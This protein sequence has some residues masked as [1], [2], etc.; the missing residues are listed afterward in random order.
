MILSDSPSCASGLGRITRDLATRLHEHCSDVFE[1]A[2]VGYGGTGNP[3]LK[4]REF[5]LHSVDNWLPMQLPEIWRK[6]VKEDEGILFSVWDLS[7][8]WWLKAPNCPPL[9]R[10]WLDTAKVKKWLYHPID[11]EGPGGKMSARLAD[12]FTAFDRVLDYTAFSC[13]VTGNTEHIPHGIDSSVFRPYD[14]IEVK[15]KFREAGFPVLQDDSFLIGIVGT[16]QARKDWA[17]GVQTCRALLD[18]GLD[19]KVWMH[20]DRLENSWSIPNLIADYGLAGRVVIT[21]ANFTDDQMAH[22]YSACDVTLGIGLGE[23]MGYPIFES[24]ACGVPCIHGDYGGAAEYLPPSMKV[25]PIAWRYEGIYCCKRPVFEVKDWADCA[26]DNRG[27]IA[28]LP[29]ALDWNGPTLWKRWE[30]YFR[31]AIQ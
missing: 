20:V 21:N 19:V 27:I 5:Y 10:Q 23:G 13:G 4:F 8:F 15:H 16:N 6:F 14:R 25:K 17:L 2:T 1:V 31:E 9:L 12:T 7:R 28:S 3:D 24:L 30:K 11:A 26:E 29:S 22:F 18:R